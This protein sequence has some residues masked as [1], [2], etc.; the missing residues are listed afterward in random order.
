L[1]LGCELNVKDIL[2]NT[3]VLTVEPNTQPGS[4]LRLRGRGLTARHTQPGDLLVK[5][6]GVIPDNIDPELVSLIEKNRAQ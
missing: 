6:K 1:I 2:G 5:L 4:V 3:L